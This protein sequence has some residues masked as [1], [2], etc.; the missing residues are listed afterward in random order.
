MPQVEHGGSGALLRAVIASKF[1]GTGF[2]KEQIV[3]TQ[4]AL[5]SA[6]EAEPMLELDVALYGL[7]G[8]F[9]S[10]AGICLPPSAL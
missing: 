6:G 4:V 1:A 3:Q 9:G 5:F 8:A 7:V 10:P 2:E